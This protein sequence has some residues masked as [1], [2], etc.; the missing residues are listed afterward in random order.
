MI[1]LIFVLA[2]V[3]MVVCASIARKRNLNGVFWVFIGGLLGPIAIPIALTVKQ[4]K[5]SKA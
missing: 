5:Y 4:G 3:S 2:L 1:S